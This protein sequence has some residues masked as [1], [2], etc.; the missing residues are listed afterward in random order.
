MI[1][2]KEEILAEHYSRFNPDGK[3]Y[4]TDDD[5]LSAMTEFGNQ[6]YAEGI[7]KMRDA[8][9]EKAEDRIGNFKMLIDSDILRRIADELLNE[10]NK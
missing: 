9:I 5:I 6:R 2:T 7:E 1:K 10:F 8:C 3:E 4:R